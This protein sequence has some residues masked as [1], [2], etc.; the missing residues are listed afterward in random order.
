M[1]DKVDEWI[2]EICSAIARTEPQS[3]YAAFIAGF[4]HKLSYTMRTILDIEEQLDKLRA[5]EDHA[6]QVRKNKG[7]TPSRTTANAENKTLKI[8]PEP[9][10]FDMDVRSPTGDSP[11][12]PP[13]Q[14]R[15]E[16]RQ[17]R[18]RGHGAVAVQRTHREAGVDPEDVQLPRGEGA[19]GGNARGPRADDQDPVHGLHR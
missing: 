6:Q 18:V 5:Q 10:S 13:V 12:K 11:T 17:L 3:A 1:H 2:R 16:E 14:L 15:L 9:D 7:S 19:D 4:K 8:F